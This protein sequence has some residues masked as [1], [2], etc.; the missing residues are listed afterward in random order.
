MW[1]AVHSKA[2]W[3]RLFGSVLYF[4]NAHELLPG[5]LVNANEHISLLRGQPLSFDQV[6]INR[7]CWEPST[8][9]GEEEAVASVAPL[10]QRV[11]FLISL[12]PPISVQ[13]NQVIKKQAAPVV[14]FVLQSKV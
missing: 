1:L 5:T 11:R 8:K 2:S 10:S 6:N 4:I 12:S 14:F 3:V 13:V 9:A 7:S